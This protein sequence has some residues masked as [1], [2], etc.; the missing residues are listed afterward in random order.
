MFVTRF[1]AFEICD[2]GGWGWASSTFV[3]KEFRL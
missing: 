2:K 3:T 1:S